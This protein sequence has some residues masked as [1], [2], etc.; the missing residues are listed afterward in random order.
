MNDR[1]ALKILSREK[2]A[3][4]RK[5]Q[6]VS[7]GDGYVSPDGMIRASDY[8]DAC[9]YVMEILRERIMQD[10]KIQLKRFDLKKPRPMTIIELHQ[11]YDAECGPVWISLG[12]SVWPAIL[13]MNDNGIVAIWAN[14]EDGVLYEENYGVTWTA[15]LTRREAEEA[16][17]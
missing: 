16:I 1:D 12:Y 13:D 14:S 11:H 7:N 10:A 9:S 4:Q 17:Q 15:Y 5:L 8:V 3:V 2:E 6:D